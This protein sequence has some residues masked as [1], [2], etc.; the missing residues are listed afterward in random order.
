MSLPVSVM[1]IISLHW[2]WFLVTVLLAQF[3][4]M[5]ALLDI[6][7][8]SLAFSCLS[9]LSW[10]VSRSVYWFSFSFLTLPWDGQP[11]SSKIELT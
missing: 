2:I 6:P 3:K 1:I 8:S 9:Y 7:W 4:S 11:N 5:F 10:F